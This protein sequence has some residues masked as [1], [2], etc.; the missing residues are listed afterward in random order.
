MSEFF[1]K[2]LNI[3]KIMEGKREYKAHMARV[4]ALP[5]DY[6]F[7][8]KKIQGYMWTFA[9]GDGMDMLKTQVDLIDLFEQS[10]MDGKHILE[11]TGED[12]VAFC[13]ELLRDTESWMDTYRNRLNR[14]VLRKFEKGR[15]F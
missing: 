5:E 15:R 4:D 6:R 11:V 10:A 8:Y 14:E 12:V 1:D 3:K 7:V 13:D 9:G 2:Y